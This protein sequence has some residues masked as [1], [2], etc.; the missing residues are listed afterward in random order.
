MNISKTSNQTLRGNQIGFWFFK[1]FLRFGGLW[2]AYTLLTG[3]SLHYWLF[4]RKAVKAATAYLKRR[5]PSDSKLLI[6]LK[7]YK[8]FYSQG[9]QLIDRFA[10]ITGAAQFHFDF[11]GRDILNKI[12]SSEKGFILLMTHAGNWQLAMAELTELKKKIFL[13]IRKEENRAVQKALNINSKNNTFGIISPEEH[14][15][16]VVPV[17]KELNNGN[18][19]SY[20]GDRSYGF[21]AVEINFMNDK[22][23]F[24]YGAFAI[25]AATKVPV[26]IGLS[27]KTG[28]KNYKVDFTNIIKPEYKGRK[29]KKEQLSV[30]VQQYA[31]IL[32]NFFAEYPYQCF[33]FHDVWKD[34]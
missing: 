9:R 11:I 20:M 3:V 22:A 27:S 17:V 33:L 5:F 31:D 25:A 12:T 10:H 2:A 13:V 30:W 34:R 4:D 28:L 8:L 6:R 1:I 24:P 19:V 18:A 26:V 14:L 32:N 21:E 23:S 7:V 16:G 15:G 29:N